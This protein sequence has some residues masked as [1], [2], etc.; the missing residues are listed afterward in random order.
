MVEFTERPTL[1]SMFVEA[2]VLG[3]MHLSPVAVEASGTPELNYLDGER[4]VLI[5]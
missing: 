1:S 4:I 3:F 2:R 5:I